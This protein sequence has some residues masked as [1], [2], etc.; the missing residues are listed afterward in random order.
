MKVSAIHQIL[1]D[2]IRSYA[3]LQIFIIS[4]LLK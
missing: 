3:L 2:L 4:Q 1:H